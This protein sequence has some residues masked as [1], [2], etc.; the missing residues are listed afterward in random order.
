MTVDKELYISK[1]EPGNYVKEFCLDRSELII[2]GVTVWRSDS[3]FAN[4]LDTRR[5]MNWLLWCATAAEKQE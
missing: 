2:D 5:L 3:T 1:Y 4:I